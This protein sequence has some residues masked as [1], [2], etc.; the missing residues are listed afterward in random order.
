LKECGR[1]EIA[2]DEDGS[3]EE[4]EKDRRS[5]VLIWRDER[6]EVQLEIRGLS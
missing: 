6:V 5:S 1:Q 4:E 2:E 3:G